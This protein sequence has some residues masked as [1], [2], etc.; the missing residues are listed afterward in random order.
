VHTAEGVGEDTGVG[1]GVG[2]AV[3]TGVAVGAGAGVGVGVAAAPVHTASKGFTL[4]L[5][6]TAVTEGF[7]KVGMVDPPGSIATVPVWEMN[8]TFEFWPFAVA[9]VQ[10]TSQK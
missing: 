2:V 1:V 7:T 3:G 10:P 9:T 4:V 5:L 6:F 8:N